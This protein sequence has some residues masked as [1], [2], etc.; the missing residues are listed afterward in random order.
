MQQACVNIGCAPGS[1]SA[2]KKWWEF[3]ATIGKINKV[4]NLIASGKQR[5]HLRKADALFWLRNQLYS[6]TIN[7]IR[8]VFKDFISH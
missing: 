3:T 6:D 8:K 7:L 5:N 1:K 2:G 4:T